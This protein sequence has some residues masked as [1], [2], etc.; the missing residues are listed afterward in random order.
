MP[1]HVL[2]S[3]G[4]SVIPSLVTVHAAQERKQL[5]SFVIVGGGPTGVEVAAELSKSGRPLRRCIAAI[6]QR[7]I[8]SFPARRRY[9]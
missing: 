5:L 3:Q 1:L 2:A 6:S 9:V 8:V 4:V 7:P